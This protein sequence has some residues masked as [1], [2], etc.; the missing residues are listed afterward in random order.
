MN[1][2][3][4]I[5]P[6]EEQPVPESQPD[7]KVRKVNDLYTSFNK[8]AL[9]GKG[10]F[11]NVQIWYHRNDAEIFAAKVF[12]REIDY[13]SELE[14][15]SK[16]KHENVVKFVKSF[17]DEKVILMELLSYS[18]DQLIKE[19]TENHLGLSESLVR[20]LI[21]DTSNAIAYLINGLNIVHRDIKPANILFDGQ[22]KSFVLADFGLAKSFNPTTR[23]YKDILSGTP[24]FLDPR[25]YKKVS[26]MAD[27]K[28]PYDISIHTELWSLA[29]TYFIA[30]TGR[31]PF[32]PTR[33]RNAWL[34][35]A[36]NKPE[37]C[38]WIN[39]KQEYKRELEGYHRLSLSFATDVF[40]PLLV[41]MMS[42]T[43]KFEQFFERVDVM[44]RSDTVHVLDIRTFKLHALYFQFALDSLETVITKAFDYPN[45]KL[46][47]GMSFLPLTGKD[48]PVPK[49]TEDNPILLFATTKD[50]MLNLSYVEHRL[51]KAAKDFFDGKTRF[52][53]T[54]VQCVLTNTM[55][56][57]EDCHKYVRSLADSE[58]VF[59]TVVK[60]KQVQLEA[61]Y[62][63]FETQIQSFFKLH[64]PSSEFRNFVSTMT[65]KAKNALTP[66]DTNNFRDK[67]IISYRDVVSLRQHLDLV[68]QKKLK[69][70]LQD[71]VMQTKHAMDKAIES[72]LQQVRNFL[73]E[74]FNT[75]ANYEQRVKDLDNLL[76]EYTYAHTKLN[77][78]IV[79]EIQNVG[80]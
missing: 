31:H 65:D 59:S 49:T 32:H 56:I 42:E 62:N 3:K 15:V 28:T 35:L 70:G 71:H 75:M 6:K 36:C 54:E 58:M 22:H 50:N 45:L 51:F 30:A 76:L 63:C 73:T 8:E 11:G 53:D 74:Y 12:K 29:V 79:N 37:D 41:S 21:K 26:Q 61:Q 34:D 80:K 77:T 1:R 17:D 46:I 19:R 55:T 44:M 48:T 69:V 5:A 38:F 10:T 52:N 39:E 9:L 18:L 33:L 24:N 27:K 25:L 16:L 66:L 13:R 72:V 64:Q 23:Q 57:I 67:D 4:R 43:A 20:T 60:E 68:N 47:H 40:T 78:Q 14:H 7:I 2:R